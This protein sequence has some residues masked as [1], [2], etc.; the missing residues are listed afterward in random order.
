MTIAAT[1]RRELDEG[2]ERGREGYCCTRVRKEKI[3][4]KKRKIKWEHKEEKEL[5]RWW[6]RVVVT[7][8]Y[9]GARGG[10]GAK[11]DGVSGDK[12]EVQ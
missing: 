9:G 2:V 11:M 12:E 5:F 3:L 4:K 6:H 8:V 1:V 10:V 7:M